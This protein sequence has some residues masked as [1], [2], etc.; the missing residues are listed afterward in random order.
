MLRT[1]TFRKTGSEAGFVTVGLSNHPCREGPAMRNQASMR[2]QSFSKVSAND[3]ACK[4]GHPGKAT[5]GKDCLNDGRLLLQKIEDR[6]AL[7]LCG[8]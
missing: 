3:P 8:D 1:G 6:G 4:A 2:M 5:G 7:E